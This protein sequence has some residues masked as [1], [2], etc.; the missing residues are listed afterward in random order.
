MQQEICIMWNMLWALFFIFLHLTLAI[1]NMKWHWWYWVSW[2]LGRVTWLIALNEMHITD[3]HFP[4]LVVVNSMWR[5]ILI[6]QTTQE[7]TTS[8]KF[9]FYFNLSV[10][11]GW[12]FNVS[13]CKAK[14]TEPRHPVKPY[15][16]LYSTVLWCD[17]WNV[18]PFTSSAMITLR[19]TKAVQRNIWSTRQNDTLND[20]SPTL[21]LF[22]QATCL[23]Q[24]GNTMLDSALYCTTT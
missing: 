21:G 12:H 18:I 11:D 14:E 7:Y 2:D 6:F 8:R 15:R 5:N 24:C 3:V 23:I 4:S 19:G 20:R 13:K 9:W 1:W 22:P 16:L 17:V 10:L